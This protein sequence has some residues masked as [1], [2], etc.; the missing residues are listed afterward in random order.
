[1]HVND[2]RLQMP[3]PTMKMLGA[4]HN[5]PAL[6]FRSC[7]VRGSWIA[8]DLHTVVLITALFL[9]SRIRSG[10]ENVMSC[11]TKPRG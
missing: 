1:M 2:V 10:N 5:L 8:I 9:G 3:N 11:G 7:R 6:A 4:S